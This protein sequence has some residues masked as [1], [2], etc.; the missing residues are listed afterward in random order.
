MNEQHRAGLRQTLFLTLA[1]PWGA[2]TRGG[3]L[4]VGGAG[5]GGLGLVLVALPWPPAGRVAPL[6]PLSTGHRALGDQSTR[7][8]AEQL[9]GN[10]LMNYGDGNFSLIEGTQSYITQWIR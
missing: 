7:L 9:S 6:E 10:A 1:G 2:G 4:G 3:G 5:L 8:P